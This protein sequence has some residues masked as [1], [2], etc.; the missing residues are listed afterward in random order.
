MDEDS[1]KERI[2]K[3]QTMNFSITKCPLAVYEEFTDFCKAETNDNY[4]FG[5]KLLLNA[6]KANIKELMLYEQYMLLAERVKAL[7]ETIAALTTNKQE[8]ETPTEEPVKKTPK[9][10]G[11][12]KKLEEKK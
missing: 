2:E 5:I 1:T 4:S 3:M 9:T 7:E 8:N 10:M 11:S 6:N 12:N